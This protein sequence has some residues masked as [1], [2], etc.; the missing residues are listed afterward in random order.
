[1]ITGFYSDLLS[2]GV[3][4]PKFPSPSGPAPYHG[5]FEAL[6]PSYPE[7]PAVPGNGSSV[8]EH[9]R[10]GIGHLNSGHPALAIESFTRAELIAPTH[11]EAF[12]QRS[13]AF[14]QASEFE[15]A[16]RDVEVY[17]AMNPAD[18]DGYL[19]QGSIYY[20]SLLDFSKAAD[21]YA[22]AASLC[23]DNNTTHLWAA[24]A[25]YYQG[26]NQEA[27]GYYTTALANNPRIG[28]ALFRRGTAHALLGHWNPALQD[29]EDAQEF[30]ADDELLGQWIQAVKKQI[31]A[32]TSGGEGGEADTRPD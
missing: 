9:L 2:I 5:Q 26:K 29:L 22:L 3:P 12:L 30:M 28:E 27:I 32:T 20:N 25:Y 13:R 15:R 8:E 6:P 10:E 21:S 14:V 7:L 1:M 19:L 4:L 31:S 18:C 16:V 24:D 23:P 17:I 11:G